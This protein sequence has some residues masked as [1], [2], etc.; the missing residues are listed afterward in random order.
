MTR[1]HPFGVGPDNYRLEYGK[2]LG[3]LK[4]DTDVY[5]NDLLLEI[6]TGSGILG[7]AA[8]V[9]FL[10]AI[11]WRFDGESLSIGIFL[12]HGLVD[13]FLMATPI[14]FCFWLLTGIRLSFNY[15]DRDPV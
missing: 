2:Y 4:W 11:P 13:V 7:L 9:W 10:F 1:A 5:S 15:G 12:I 6:L 8:F 14:Y 3:A